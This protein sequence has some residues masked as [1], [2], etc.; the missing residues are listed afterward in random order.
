MKNFNHNR[1]KILLIKIHIKFTEL[2]KLLAKTRFLG[3]Y[4][5]LCGLENV[6]TQ[7]E[8]EI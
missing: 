4:K 7:E 1:E 2:K 8:K 3:I 5:I 6:L